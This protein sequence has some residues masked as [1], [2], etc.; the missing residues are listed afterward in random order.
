MTSLAQT[1]WHRSE[2]TR[3]MRAAV[4]YL[5]PECDSKRLQAQIPSFA[6]GTRPGP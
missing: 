6:N 4:V 5:R 1:R 2:S 3:S